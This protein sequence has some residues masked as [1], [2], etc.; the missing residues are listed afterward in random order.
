M[1]VLPAVP[2]RSASR[3]AV[4][5]LP[6]EGTVGHMATSITKSLSPGSAYG[7]FSTCGPWTAQATTASGRTGR[8][9]SW[10]LTRRQA[11]QSPTVAPGPQKLR[12]VR[13]EGGLKYVTTKGAWSTL[14]FTGSDV[15]CVAPKDTNRGKAVVYL[16]DVKGATID[17]YSSSTTPRKVVFM[18]SWVSSRP[19][20]LKVWVYGTPAKRPRGRR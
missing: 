2:G 5:T 16:D 14:R 4:L 17:L 19:H 9:L 18:K 11:A 8:N 6:C 7:L 10:T 12:A 1:L 13:T 20:Q 15:A 3:P